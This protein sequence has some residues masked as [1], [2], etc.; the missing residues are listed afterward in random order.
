MSLVVWLTA[1]VHGCSWQVVLTLLAWKLYCPEGLHMLRGNHEVPSVNEY[2]GF[3]DELQFK[4]R[5]EGDRIRDGFND[6]F[7]QLPLG[8]IIADRILTV[9]GGIPRALNDE[10]FTLDQMR[11]CPR[12]SEPE[13]KKLLSD[14]LW[15]DP[16]DDLGTAESERNAGILFGPDVT[17]KFLQRTGLECI[18][19]AHQVRT[20]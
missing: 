12:E 13:L 15:S 11:K 10:S 19:R 20:T 17:Q 4:Y 5:Q 16:H 18:I 8:A 6:L 7:T 2:Y 14:V 3:K 1:A 9:H